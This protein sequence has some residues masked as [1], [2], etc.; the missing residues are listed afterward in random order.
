M[1]V[2]PL[3]ALSLSAMTLAAAAPSTLPVPAGVTQQAL[4][5]DR[6]FA[7]PGLAGASPR[8]V[9]LS[10]DGRL[11]TVLRNRADDRERYDLWA[12]D[13]VTGQWRMLVDSK[14]IGSGAAISEAEK[15]Q[16]E[17]ARVGGLKGII[18]YEW[19]PDSKALLVPIDGDLY[20]ADLAGKTRRLTESKDSE[21]NPAIS[22]KGRY[23]SFVRDQKLWVGPVGGAARAVT[24]G[25][26]TIHYG[27]AE[28]VAQEELDRLTGYWWAP[29]DDR[30]AVQ[31]FDE[32][33]VGVVTRTSIGTEGT[34]TF[35][36][37]Y[38]AAGTPNVVPH[39]VIIDP[40]GGKKV[41]VDLGA[42]KDVYL[43]RVNWARDGR[44][45]YVQRLNRV[46]DRLDMLTVD[47][48][49]GKS[50]LLFSETARQGHWINL[51]SNY[52]WLKDGSLVW[53]SERDG[54]GQLY[55]FA[56][57]QWTR[58]TD[59]KANVLSLAGVD[60]VGG[61][62]YFEANPD[63]TAAQVYVA[64]LRTPG[65]AAMRLSDSNFRNSASMDKLATRLLISRSSPSQP[66]QTYLA[67]TDG[68]RIAWV[69]ENKL[70]ARHPYSPYLASH[71]PASYGS[72]KGPSGDTLY[73]RMITPANMMPGKHYPVFFSHYG[74]PHSQVVTR[75][76]DGELAQ[77]IVDKGYIWFEIDNRGSA[78]RGV[79]FE[80]PINRAMGSV[81]VADQK[82]GALFLETQS[83]VDPNRIA[84]YGWSYGGYAALQ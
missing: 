44:T 9:K 74:G 2:R 41:I 79:E 33:S 63:V 3:M 35:E 59:G 66:S 55:R 62:L 36:Q 8:G 21:L 5:L 24:P 18:N 73:Y 26:G 58:L 43:A 84:T 11:L 80:R 52:R 49:T 72:I 15:M 16:R 70:D 4:T 38:P 57:G 60:E 22:P 50:R 51:T 42:D 67:G 14:Q 39:L 13:T 71:R 78:G 20:L 47:P 6:V 82:A 53:L 46:Q 31:W 37:R 12:L 32:A 30:L 77:Y 76:W 54:I 1:Q 17:R 29:N 28:F 65:G 81:E 34:T 10:P 23:V 19:A 68:Q 25:G 64:D 40:A 7:S 69:E 75:G 56:A 45:L 48:A 27:E 83:F 61:K